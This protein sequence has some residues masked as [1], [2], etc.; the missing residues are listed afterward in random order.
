M[1]F[2][3]YGGQ[4]NLHLPTMLQVE[5]GLGSAEAASLFALYNG[6]AIFGKLLPGVIFSA[7]SFRERHS[8]WFAILPFSLLYTL[9][10]LVLLRIDPSRLPPGRL[11][12]S[13]G[14]VLAALSFTDSPQRLSLFCCAWSASATALASAS[15]LSSCVSSSG[16]PPSPCCSPSCKRSKAS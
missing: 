8:L 4:L 11:P 10:H 14:E 12:S 13:F 16:L 2:F 7:P 5:S 1:C 15:S 3:L 6:L 9:S